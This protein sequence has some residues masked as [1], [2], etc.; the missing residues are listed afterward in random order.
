M[1]GYLKNP[2]L[3]RICITITLI[4]VRRGEVAIIKLCK[5]ERDLPAFNTLPFLVRVFDGLKF[6]I[7]SK[8]S[9]K[10]TFV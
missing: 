9:C 8:V 3:K 7:L 5:R 1:R 4:T 10:W 6:C 2:I